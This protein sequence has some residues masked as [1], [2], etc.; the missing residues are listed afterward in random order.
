MD[1]NILEKG[2]IKHLNK[3]IKNNSKVI[4]LKKFI[5]KKDSLS[6]INHCHNLSDKNNNFISSIDINP[7]K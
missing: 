1:I 5:T 6:I 3:L 4:I 7:K 2:K